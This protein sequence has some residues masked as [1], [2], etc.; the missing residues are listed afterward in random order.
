M[1]VVVLKM[2]LMRRSSRN[3]QHRLLSSLRQR[4]LEASLLLL[5]EVIAQIH[6]TTMYVEAQMPPQHFELIILYDDVTVS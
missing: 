2:T 6:V 5:L 3:L 4:L 1:I